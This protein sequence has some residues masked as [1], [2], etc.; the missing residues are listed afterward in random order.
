MHPSDI[1]NA[2]RDGRR[3]R[4]SELLVR[5]YTRSQILEELDKDEKFF[6]PR[7]GKSWDISVVKR[8]VDILRKRWQEEALLNYD[9]HVSRIMAQIREVRRKAWAEENLS[10]VLRTLKQEIDL[11]GLEAATKQQ[12]DWREELRKAGVNDPSKQFEDMVQEAYAAMM[13]REDIPDS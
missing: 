13:A 7:T 12:I 6:N 3:Q 8:D 4:V 9:I 11:F 5:G 1:Y 2:M 10:I